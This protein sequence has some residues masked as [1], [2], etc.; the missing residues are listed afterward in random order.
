MNETFLVQQAFQRQNVFTNCDSL[1]K[2]LQ[3]YQCAEFDSV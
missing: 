1:L 3:Q 2:F